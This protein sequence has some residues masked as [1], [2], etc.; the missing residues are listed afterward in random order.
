MKFYGL[1]LFELSIFF[2]IPLIIFI[3]ILLVVIFAS[4]KDAK[5]RAQ[6]NMP[7][8]ALMATSAPPVIPTASSSPAQPPIASSVPTAT[9]TTNNVDSAALATNDATIAPSVE[10]IPGASASAPIPLPPRP[11]F[12][13]SPLRGYPVLRFWKTSVAFSILGV[14]ANAMTAWAIA[15][16]AF[17]ILLP[18][19][20][21]GIES[22]LGALTTGLIVTMIAFIVYAALGIVYAAVFYRS[23]FTE[24]PRLTSS[25]AISFLNLFFGGIIFG[26]IW[27]Y[28]LTRSQMS[29]KLQK[30]SSSIVYIVLTAVAIAS[31]VLITCVYVPILSVAQDYY[32]SQATRVERKAE[33]DSSRESKARDGSKSANQPET[34]GEGDAPNSSS[35]P[36]RYVDQSY[37]TSFSAPEGWEQTILSEERDAYKWK[38]TSPDE[39]NVVLLYGAFDSEGEFERT[40]DITEEYLAGTIS[41]N[42]E[43]CTDEVIDNANVNGRAYWKMTGSGLLETDD[44]TMPVSTTL[45]IT[46]KNGIL[47]VFGYDDYSQNPEAHNHYSDFLNLLASVHYGDNSAPLDRTMSTAAM[48][49]N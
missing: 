47:Y 23:Y 35:S 16:I 22:M 29:S 15:A 13:Y 26:C 1:G 32:G 38:A 7:N 8:A 2:F 46:A 4:R 45:Y 28:N 5:Q 10:S 40:S 48:K 49:L 44:K 6:E 34:T 30:G 12:D 41:D 27:N 37:N 3:V 20:A 39:T 18:S 9:M 14:V 17:L 19:F 33:P 43:N 36:S 25:K 42:L 24:K 11:S 31:F 21:S